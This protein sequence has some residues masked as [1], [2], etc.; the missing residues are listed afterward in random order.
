M[1]NPMKTATLSITIPTYNRRG[2]LIKTLDAII[3]QLNDRCDLT[4]I[5][6]ASPYD[7]NSV[8]NEIVEKHGKQHQ[9]RLIIR[10]RNIGAGGNIAGC[11]MEAKG[12][13]AWILSDD[14]TVKE[15]AVEKILSIICNADK[16]IFILFSRE[17]KKPL[18][19][20]TLISNSSTGMREDLLFGEFLFISCGVYNV[21]AV[22]ENLAWA[23]DFGYSCGGHF[24]MLAKSFYEK[25]SIITV[26]S[27]D[28]VRMG[29]GATPDW[30][31]TIR[32]CVRLLSLMELPIPIEAKTRIGA[33]IRA[34]YCSRWPHVIWCMISSASAEKERNIKEGLA[35]AYWCQWCTLHS[36]FRRSDYLRRK[37]ERLV[38]WAIFSIPKFFV[39][40]RLIIV[41]AL[42]RMDKLQQDGASKPL[43]HRI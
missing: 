43:Y 12:K 40:L 38:L 28:I 16:S 30:T 24:A 34:I 41:K 27:S 10:T 20:E 3:P 21:D 32:V 23:Y 1:H 6:N 33:S 37:L 7:V 29:Q 31:N 22:K 39:L 13:W 25:E 19:T 9:C 4:V 2:C 5:D 11:L 15:N 8:F 18:Q 36:R 26:S 35:Y 17:G 14:D 42:G